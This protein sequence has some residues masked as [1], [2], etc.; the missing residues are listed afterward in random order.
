MIDGDDSLLALNPDATLLAHA[1]GNDIEL[2]SVDGSLLALKVRIPDS[3]GEL[4]PV[5]NE[6]EGGRLERGADAVTAL[7]WLSCV[8]VA[9]TTVR[10]AHSATAPATARS[11]T[12]ILG[13]NRF[14][15]YAT[16]NGGQEGRICERP[17]MIDKQPIAGRTP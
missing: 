5:R 15:T 8:A 1:R 4:V 16:V 14:I 11:T 12:F 13:V 6:A 2:W 17:K 9:A 3:S 7:Q 10:T